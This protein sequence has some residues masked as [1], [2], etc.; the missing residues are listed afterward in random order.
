[1]A[2]ERSTTKA[3]HDSVISGLNGTAL[4]LAVYASP[5]PLLDRT[6]DSLL[7]AG[8]AL[9]G[10]ICTRRVP[11]KGFCNAQNITSSSPKLFLAQAGSPWEL[12]PRAPADPDLRN[13][14]IRLVSERVCQPLCYPLRFR[15]RVSAVRCPLPVSPQR[16]RSSAAPSLPRV[17][18]VAVPL[19]HRY[20]EPLRRPAAHLAALRFLRLAIPPGAPVFVASASPTP[21]WDLEF[22]GLATPSQQKEWRRQGL[23]GSWGTLMCLCPVL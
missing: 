19:L 7:V 9:P 13:S 18:A 20:Y 6:Q 23:P 21:A 11:S 4:A 1:M 14:R 3:P 22:S 17:R 8:Q 2:P 16:F 12:P 10:G 15:V 5:G